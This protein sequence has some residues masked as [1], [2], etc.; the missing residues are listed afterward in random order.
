MVLDSKGTP[1]H[2]SMVKVSH[3]QGTNVMVSYHSST[4]T[5]RESSVWYPSVCPVIFKKML[6]F[7]CALMLYPESLFSIYDFPPFVL[8]DFLAFLL[9]SFLSGRLSI[10]QYPPSG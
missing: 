4:R 8:L 5:K 9:S 7:A 6:T 2:P 10:S 1:S 3:S